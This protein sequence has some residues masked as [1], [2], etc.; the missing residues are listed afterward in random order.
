[1][2]PRAADFRRHEPDA[3]PGNDKQVQIPEG[4]DVL[5]NEAGTAPGWAL[6]LD[7]GMVAVFPG[8][9]R[10]NGP[11]MTG[12]F[13][14]WLAD[15]VPGRTRWTVRVFRT[16]GLAESEVGHRLKPLEE[17]LGDIRLAY[18]YH[19]PE[20]LVKLRVPA[21][22]EAAADALAAEIRAAL[23]PALYGEGDDDLPAVLGHRLRIAGR[24]IVTAESC[25]GGLAGKLLTDPPGATKWFE[26]GFVTYTNEA[27]TE[28]LR[29]PRELIRDRGAVSEEVAA[30]MLRGALERSAADV[31]FSITGIAGPGGGS[32]E[33][34]V[35]T[36]CIAWGDREAIETHT[37]HL[38]WD[39]DYNRIVS[40]W[41]AMARV[42]RLLEA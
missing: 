28:L 8:P 18:Q 14:A 4:A 27:K 12:P 9:P 7:G 32:P 38:R 5:V 3:A 11:M 30:A 23:A 26:R 42:L 10:E 6:A 2:D 25:T 21:G 15:R 34:P 40:V 36:V 24:R 37:L 41:S 35:G 13:A 1:M 39:R 29:V 17:R 22:A 16:F 19:F 33:K 20:V 31:G